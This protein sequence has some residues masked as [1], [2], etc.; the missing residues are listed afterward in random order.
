MVAFS[1]VN[2]PMNMMPATYPQSH[3]YPQDD[4]HKTVARTLSQGSVPMSMDFHPVQQTLLLGKSLNVSSH[5]KSWII[6]S[7]P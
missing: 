5:Y 2:L 7:L 6:L 3:S 1:Q 4:F